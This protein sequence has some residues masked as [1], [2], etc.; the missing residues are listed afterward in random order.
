MTALLVFLLSLVALLA[1]TFGG[2]VNEV[3]LALGNYTA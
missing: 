3:L 2:F 1:K